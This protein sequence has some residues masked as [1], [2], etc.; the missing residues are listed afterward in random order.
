MVNEADLFV[1]LS[2][3]H[4]TNYQNILERWIILAKQIDICGNYFNWNYLSYKVK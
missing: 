3:K 4:R 1:N 2:I